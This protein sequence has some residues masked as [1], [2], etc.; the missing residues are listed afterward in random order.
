M[1]GIQLKMS[2]CAKNQENATHNEE[3]T[4]LIEIDPEMTL[5]RQ[6]IDKDIKTLL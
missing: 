4:Q 6:F 2:G 5:M 3:E 1:S